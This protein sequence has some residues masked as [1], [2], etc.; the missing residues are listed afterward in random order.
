MGMHC[1][2][3][4]VRHSNTKQRSSKDCQRNIWKPNRDKS[5]WGAHTVGPHQVASYNIVLMK[6]RPYDN[7][8]SVI[9]PSIPGYV[10]TYEYF[11]KFMII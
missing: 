9:V 8:W 2:L 4:T 3:Y 11:L 10:V 5:H 6:H 7:I 1:N